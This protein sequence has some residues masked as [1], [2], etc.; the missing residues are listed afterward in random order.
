L[1]G[2]SHNFWQTSTCSN[3]SKTSMGSYS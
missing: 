3:C 1:L 2:N